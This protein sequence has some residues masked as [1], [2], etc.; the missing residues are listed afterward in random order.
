MKYNKTINFEF[1]MVE[2]KLC[3]INNE[4]TVG[5]LTT[6]KKRGNKI[7]MVF[8]PDKVIKVYKK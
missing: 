4:E 5:L 1:Y 2:L 8:D 3:A 6:I 7:A